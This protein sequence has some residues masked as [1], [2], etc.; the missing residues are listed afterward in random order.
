VLVSDVYIE[1]DKIEKNNTCI[2]SSFT[3]VTDLDKLVKLCAKKM[4]PGTQT[5]EKNS[6]NEKDTVG[7]RA[8]SQE[9]EAP[10]KGFFEGITPILTKEEIPY[11]PCKENIP[12]SKEDAAGWTNWKWT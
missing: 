6:V 1:N 11:L 9:E 2:P 5:S 3:N 8:Q 12:P 4:A 7:V 10:R